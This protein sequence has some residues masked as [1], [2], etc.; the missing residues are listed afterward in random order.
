MMQSFCHRLRVLQVDGPDHRRYDLRDLVS[1]YDPPRPGRGSP[2]R[3]LRNSR[4]NTLP[5]KNVA[6]EAL[7]MGGCEDR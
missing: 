4:N 2:S 1:M 3:S 5:L 7:A 6:D